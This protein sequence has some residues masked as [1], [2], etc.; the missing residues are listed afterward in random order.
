MSSRS[1]ESQ[2]C[3]AKRNVL[4][5]ESRRHPGVRAPDRAGYTLAHG[6]RQLRVAPLAFWLF[7][8]T[9][10]G[11]AVWTV[12][13]ATYFAFREDVLTRLIARQADMQF[14]YEDRIA[15]LRA[16]VDRVSSRQLLDQ[17]QYEQTLEQNSPPPDSAGS[18]GKCARW[19]G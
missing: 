19:I 10:A 18:A 14:G 1:L 11:M 12:T 16:Q 4:V 5:S 15:E 8:S 7:L 17:D 9:L 3:Q 13:T 2:Y 6:G